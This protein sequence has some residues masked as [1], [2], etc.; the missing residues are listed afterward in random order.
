[1]RVD[2]P[3]RAGVALALALLACPAALPPAEPVEA[4]APE[5]PAG[6]FSAE[7]AWRHLGALERLGPRPAG[8]EG[9]ARARAYLADALRGQGLEVVELHSPASPGAPDATPETVGLLAT[10]G[11]SSRDLILLFARYD[12]PGSPGG[13]SADVASGAALVLELGRALR[14]R[15]SAYTVLLAFVEGDAPARG[16]GA[17]ES[18]GTGALVA[19]LAAGDDLAR[20]RLAVGFDRLEAPDLR[21][22][23]DLHSSRTLREEFWAAARHLGHTGIFEPGAPFETVDAG[24]RAFADAGMRRFVAIVGSRPAPDEAEPRAGAD[25]AER[26][27]RANLAAVGAVSLDA[28]ESISRRL[29][30]IDRFVRSP[31][32]SEPEVAD[33]P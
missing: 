26:A 32:A 24:H 18:V 17:P 7:R 10:L 2:L 13:A 31:I 25:D 19:A 20:V 5:P 21:I 29:A 22:A 11:W 12:S 1:M 14:A 23:R 28:I 4:P 9:A 8:S 15:G 33:A 6:E 27:S 16:A 3:S 30:K